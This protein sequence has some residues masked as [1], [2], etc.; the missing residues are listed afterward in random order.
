MSL[1]D[2]EMP[3]SRRRA[4]N[5]GLRPGLQLRLPAIV[6]GATVAFGLLFAAHTQA[7]YGRFVAIGIEHPGLRALVQDQGRD[8]L[9]VSLA[10]GLAY[11]MVILLACL[12]QAHRLLGPVVALRRH[13]EG[14][15]NG[16]Y[17]SRLSLRT[18]DPFND[19]ADDLNELA[20]ILRDQQKR[21][22]S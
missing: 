6:V 20:A 7:A 19:I 16:D 13:L 15:K 18:N 9:I 5:L 1:R 17:V 3:G 22:N 2:L 14:M 12:I 11:V 10:I 8:F 4:I 21:A